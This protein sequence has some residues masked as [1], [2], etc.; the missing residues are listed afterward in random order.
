MLLARYEA[1]A[2]RAATQSGVIL[3]PQQRAWVLLQAMRISPETWNQ[4]LMPLQ[5]R[6]PDT[7][8][9]YRQFLEYVR[10][11]QH[12]AEAGQMS[13]VQGATTQG[14]GVFM[15]APLSGSATTH[16][17]ATSD[18]AWQSSCVEATYPALGS[19]KKRLILSDSCVRLVV[20]MWVNLNGILAT[21]NR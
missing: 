1:T 13:I 7:E 6:L 17:F 20:R 19:G 8:D 9:G 5:G 12:I 14:P 11:S 4:L 21:I 16:S 2:A 15:T 10:R 18:P 3:Q